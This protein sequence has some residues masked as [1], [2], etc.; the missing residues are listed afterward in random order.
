MKLPRFVHTR[1]R[2]LVE[3]PRKLRRVIEKA[4]RKQESA[5]TARKLKGVLAD[6]RTLLRLIQ[7][8]MGG[9]YSNISKANLVLIVGAIVYFLMPIDVFPDFIPVGGFV[10]DVAVII[11]VVDAVKEELAKFK[12]W[13]RHRDGLPA[14]GSV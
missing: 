13:E 7:A 4:Q 3:S 9:K 1:A 12:E 10:D 5:R 11:W 2:R 14:L 6:L 8:W